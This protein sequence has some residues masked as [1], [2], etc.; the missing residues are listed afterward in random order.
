M[1]SGLTRNVF[2]I[3]E[4]AVNGPRRG[5]VA[6]TFDGE[7]R[8]FAAVHER[9]L[10]VAAGLAAEGVAAG[11]RV[12]VL[13]GNRHE[14]PEVFF[15]LAALGAVCVPVN[16]LLTPAEVA[17]VCGDSDAS[18]MVVDERAQRAIDQLSALPDL[19][20]CV[21]E[22]DVP[23]GQRAV[24]Y[25]AVVGAAP[26]RSVHGPGLDDLAILYYSSGTTGLP[27]AAAHTH[28]GVLW[29]SYHQ[30]P[31]FGLTRDDVYLVVP[32]L[33]WAAGFHD[34]TLALAWLGGR[35]VLTPTG[36]STPERLIRVVEEQGVTS[37]LLVPTL[38]RQF[39]GEPELLD[40]LR[41]SSL[42]RIITGAEPVPRAIIEALTDALPEA[43]V[44]QGYGLSEFPT[45]ATMLRPEE[46][47][48]HAGTAG[49]PCSIT[50]LA[51]QTAQGDIV[52][53]GDGE[54][55]L[56]SYATMRE[57]FG[58]PE[59]TAEAFA[60]GWLHT[61]DL[62]TVDEAGFLTITGRKKDMIISG[63]LNIYP[64]EIEEVLYTLPGVLE[65]SVV[66]V[67]DDRWG[68]SAVAIVVGDGVASDAVTQACKEQLAS[69][70]RP[71]AV[72][73]RE[74]PLPRNPTGK[75]LKRELRPWAVDR[76][77]ITPQPANGERP[78]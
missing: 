42:R 54:V 31:D 38:L 6:F 11:D 36:G 51:I 69:Y 10:R 17:H 35:S 53:A 34:V 58:K 52:S 66:G 72:L 46:A 16:V 39:L 64:R 22:L 13:L 71:R 70:K 19:L 47:I 57:Y 45:V 41:R 65:A 15:A 55:L 73:L 75:V 25:D 5:D 8:T 14:W 2:G 37:A 9:S 33:S 26:L 44:L 30:V 43:S 20:V 76:L 50:D 61:G 1:E 24:A 28:D 56:R 7:D 4:R 62:G 21:G 77:A 63:G 40:R 12:A 18:C 27:K 23:P 60:D 68:E 78:A 29:N 59:E 32:S 48:P 49:R 74:D 67:P 3:L